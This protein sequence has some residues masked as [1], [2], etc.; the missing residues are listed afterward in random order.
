MVVVVL[1]AAACGSTRTSV[2]ATS[3]YGCPPTTTAASFDPGPDVLFEGDGLT[4]AN[5][6]RSVFGLRAATLAELTT[7]EARMLYRDLGVHV[8]PEEQEA[9]RDR[10][11]V[12]AQVRVV[13]QDLSADPSYLGGSVDNVTPSWQ[14]WMRADGIARATA[15]TTGL[16]VTVTST[17]FSRADGQAELDRVLGLLDA[18]DM[19]VLASWGVGHDGVQIV[20][21]CANP[22]RDAVAKAIVDRHPTVPYTIVADV[23]SEFVLVG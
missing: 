4:E 8:L 18:A 14:V 13:L 15:A 2:G 22:R 20:I 19:D 12:D 5:Y 11:V 9:W 21:D 17:T 23:K 1:I 3:H 6:S 10:L 16:P 7:P